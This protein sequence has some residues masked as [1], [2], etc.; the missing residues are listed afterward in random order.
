M[1]TITSPS[2]VTVTVP[3]DTVESYTSAGWMPAGGPAAKPT[4]RRRGPWKKPRT[5]RAQMPPADEPATE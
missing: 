2:G 1:A 5:S 3:D 4:K